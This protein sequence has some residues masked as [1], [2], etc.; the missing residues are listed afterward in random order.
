[1]EDQQRSSRGSE[2]SPRISVSASSEEQE[3][4]LPSIPVSPLSVSFSTNS[5]DR[6]DI[7]D[8]RSST[9]NTLRPA[10][11]SQS[12]RSG[13][14]SATTSTATGD[15]DSGSGALHLPGPA[16]EEKEDTERPEI[17]HL[18][19]DPFWLRKRTL[20]ALAALFVCLAAA[21]IVLWVVN[22]AQNGFRITLSTNHYSWTYGPTAILVI[23]LS[24]WR[25]VDYHCKMMQP[26]QELRK[27][28][29]DAERSLLLDYLSPLHIT[30][31][32]RAVRHR[33]Y[34]VI[35]S[36]L[37]FATL[38]AIILLSTGLLVLTP[39]QTANEVPV[40]LTT[41][42]EKLEPRFGSLPP[43]YENGNDYRLGPSFNFTTDSV[44]EYVKT[45]RERG[46]SPG[47]LKNIVHQSFET[48]TD[49][50]LQTISMDVDAFMPNTSCEIAEPTF[51]ISR[52]SLLSVILKSKTCS[53]AQLGFSTDPGCLHKCPGNTT[54]KQWWR[55]D[56]SSM[57][58]F[59]NGSSSG[60]HT[61]GDYRTGLLMSD[62]S[63]LNIDQFFSTK[64]DGELPHEF[65]PRK[66]A[67]VICKT[68]YT[69]QVATV[70]DGPS[71]DQMTITP[72]HPKSELDTLTGD[73]L[74]VMI[75]SSLA[76]TEVFTSSW[77]MKSVWNILLYTLDGKQTIQ[78]LLSGETMQ[79]SVEQV[80]N[81]L[82]AHL[83]REL[84][85][86][87]ASIKATG[88]A[89]LIVDR[90]SV[91]PASLWAMVG[92][93]AL[94][95]VLTILVVVTR[96]RDI[97]PQDPGVLTTDV[98]VLISSMS[99]RNLLKNAGSM[100]TSAL[101]DML[102]GT[103]FTIGGD[104]VFRIETIGQGALRKHKKREIKIKT[105][106]W[107][108]LSAKYPMIISTLAL[109]VTVIIALEILYVVS[110]AKS[111]LMDV[112]GSEDTATYLSRYISASVA[113][114]IATL[115]NSVDFTTASLAPYSSLR[116][117]AISVKKGLDCELLGL[118]PPVAL[119]SSLRR[120]HAS[121]F[122]CNIAGMLGSILTIVSSGLWVVDRTVSFQQA[123]NASL[124]SSWDI[125]WSNS[126]TTGDGGAGPAFDQFQHGARSL[127]ASVWNGIVLPD[128]EIRQSSHE[129]TNHTFTVD[130]LRPVLSC[131]VIPNEHIS[132]GFDKLSNGLQSGEF[133]V[134][135]TPPL[136]P[137]CQYG[138]PNGSR[139]H[140]NF[141][142]SV[143]IAQSYPWSSPVYWTEKQSHNPP[144]YFGDFYD[145]HLGPYKMRAPQ[146][147]T[148]ANVCEGSDFGEW[149][150][151]YCNLWKDNPAGCPSIGVILARTSLYQIQEDDASVLLC[152]QMVQQVQVNVTYTRLNTKRASISTEKVPLVLESSKR[153][154]TNG[155]QGIDTFP[156]RVQAYLQEKD[157]GN[158][159]LT[160]FP[161]NFTQ[162]VHLNHFMH[163]LVFGLNGTALEN[164]AG[165]A[166]QE[167]LIRAVSN[168]YSKYMLF[169]M[170]MK[171][172]QD[173][174][175]E[176]RAS[177]AGDEGFL[178]GTAY[179]FTS[180][181]Q[182]NWA[183]KVTMQ[184][185]LGVMTL[186]G[187]CTFLSSDLRGTL[188][189]K[190][191][192]IASRMAL[193]AGSDLCDE[194]KG[195][196]PRDAIWMPR[197]EIEK[198]F[199]GWLFSLGWWQQFGRGHDNTTT[200]VRESNGEGEIGEESL[201]GR[202]TSQEEETSKHQRFGIDV[203]VP[204]QL[205]FRETKLWTVR[206][207]L[208]RRND[209]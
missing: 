28:P 45:L 15:D 163:H 22:D 101:G 119:L 138:G 209:A 72:R 84:Y 115:F 191:T 157:T 29:V 14:T 193:L 83:V 43:P 151:L 12:P 177:Q 110:E 120:R 128:I 10:S 99:L 181:L 1:M 82:G 143:W 7:Y 167:T 78:R 48:D 38:K 117:G 182:L 71:Q 17:T 159:T 130:G 11:R 68:H 81:G 2:S 3:Y 6:H 142:S 197:K 30:S 172:R 168:L 161:H 8:G 9:A 188:P 153:N 104:P 137:G 187:A 184:T 60:A 66:A 206:R 52:D 54:A 203:G 170:D 173:I 73:Y 57:K 121:S 176:A 106:A 97:I 202:T 141:S 133:A 92:G 40:T 186:L 77:S 36:I 164:L 169:V 124:S 33:H 160:L 79:S 51:F 63:H 196:I 174:A 198:L 165:K 86:R 25:Q 132:F 64:S 208:T 67:A 42:F 50:E 147:G 34:P 105:G 139:H 102:H 100:R 158:G 76:N 93:S 185:L 201:S 5:D 107:I 103:M 90:L 18:Y 19:W 62:M 162:P 175:P 20:F 69:M 134:R 32:V 152:S 166:N 41:A 194:Q 125:S 13:E 80:W 87:P 131:D 46:D 155:T 146:R 123:V 122:C 35:A 39:V 126:S 70:L 4:L 111:G 49:A 74:G 112:S 53:S 140:Y 44:Y 27:G 26:W 144:G 129:L 204:E 200:S 207:R 109:P 47:I 65:T 127:P 95:L 88:S 148:S 150:S 190:P 113:L 31:L 94:L 189:R 136:A 149:D 156:Y 192:S 75:F 59:A 55:M 85:L 37:G 205:G 98:M 61:L 89:Y 21:L 145:L 171:F 108:P 179:G 183:S 199:D 195:I 16:V 116:T 114:L 154:L 23:V 180:R 24:F 135:A 178:E 58:T 91:G 96:T 56:C 118:L